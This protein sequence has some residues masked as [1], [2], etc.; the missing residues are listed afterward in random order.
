M[1]LQVVVPLLV[2]VVTGVVGA[3]G[4]ML[5]DRRLAR[6]SRNVRT[7]ALAQ[8]TAEV[9]FASEWW[10]AQQFLGTD[11]AADCTQKLN[12]WLAQAESTVTN[13]QHLTTQHNTVTLRR[14]FLAEPMHRR[15][16]KVLRVL[17]W[18]SVLWLVAVA[19]TTATDISEKHQ[20]TWVGSDL[21]LLIISAVI[22]LFLHIWAEASE[23]H[24]S[25]HIPEVG[26]TA[27][28]GAFEPVPQPRAIDGD[29]AKT[30][31]VTH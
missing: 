19:G 21:A 9:G 12:G 25:G 20:H 16:S 10:K 22:V 3:F 26:A 27:P 18:I 31:T 13:A 5:K 6:D 7:A 15:S 1:V 23:Q 30:A 4:L 14:L 17:F 11:A 29:P 28:P 8:A 2:P 24:G